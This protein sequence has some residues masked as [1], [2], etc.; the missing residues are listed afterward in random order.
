MGTA[1]SQAAEQS[2]GRIRAR[3]QSLA[4]AVRQILLDADRIKVPITHQRCLDREKQL[5]S[6]ALAPLI[7]EAV[8]PRRSQSKVDA[9]LETIARMMR[10][11]FGGPASSPPAAGQGGDGAG[12]GG[13]ASTDPALTFSWPELVGER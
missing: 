1:T 11:E 5:L 7:A 9:E 13:V 8:P 12:G 4:G 3:R 6:D 10:K 2:L